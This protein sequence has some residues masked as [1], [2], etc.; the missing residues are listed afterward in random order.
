M[1]PVS[2]RFADQT[3]TVQIDPSKRVL[4]RSNQVVQTTDL[5]ARVQD[6]LLRKSQPAS[7]RQTLTPDDRVV[8][9]TDPTLPVLPE[10]LEPVLDQLIHAGIEPDRITLLTS[11]TGTDTEWIECLDDRFLDIRTEVHDPQ[12][13]KKLSYLASTKT[14]R[15]IYLNRSMV[16]ADQLI[17]LQRLGPNETPAERAARVLFPVYADIEIQEQ[18][19]QAH[20]K[21]SD[22]AREVIWLLGLPVILSA[23]PGNGSEI[24]D[25]VITLSNDVHTAKERYD[26]IWGGTA[27]PSDLTI[28]GLVDDRPELPLESLWRALSAA[29]KVA[30]VDTP[31]VVLAGEVAGI[32]PFLGSVR[33]AEEL[34]SE[35][36]ESSQVR[37]WLELARRN[38]LFL[39][40][41][42][43][44]DDWIE[45]ALAV[46]IRQSAELQRLIDSAERVQVLIDPHRMNLVSELQED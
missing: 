25:A 12:D 9:V 4:L 38:R 5:R 42:G 24:A 17:I 6:E 26:L 11:A 21:I 36:S 14:N 41:A 40:F 15:R 2:I 39:S 23:I 43:V 45:G 32:L 1:E 29:Q 3:W 46:S 44:D 35:L 16:D 10:L 28:L 34:D 7:L 27:A 18:F 31:I 8:I 19:N 13:S 33:Q 20:R 30:E 37:K 22:E